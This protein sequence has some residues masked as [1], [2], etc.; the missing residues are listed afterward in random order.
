MDDA[1]IRILFS[2]V[3]AIGLGAGIKY[4]VR[5]LWDY[6]VHQRRKDGQA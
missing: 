2:V 6:P 3:V 4:L 5:L 1:T